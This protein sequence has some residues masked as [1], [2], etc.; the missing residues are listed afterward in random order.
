MNKRIRKKRLKKKWEHMYSKCP[1]CRRKSL[2][3]GYGFA[4]GGGIGPYEAC[5]H[6]Q[7]FHKTVDND[8]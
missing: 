5:D 2:V 6:C 3:Y 1:A 8:L 7:Y 4:F